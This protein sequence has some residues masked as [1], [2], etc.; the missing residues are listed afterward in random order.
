MNCVSENKLFT[1]LFNRRALLGIAL[2][3]STLLPLNHAAP[4]AKSLSYSNGIQTETTSTPPPTSS[5]PVLTTTTTAKVTSTLNGTFQTDKMNDKVVSPPVDSGVDATAAAASIVATTIEKTPSMDDKAIEYNHN[6][7]T[8]KSN[9]VR[10]TTSASSSNNYLDKNNHSVLPI[11]V[12]ISESQT[13]PSSTADKNIDVLSTSSPSATTEPTAGHSD[14]FVT[15]TTFITHQHSSSTE[16]ILSDVRLQS[17]K[18]PTQETIFTTENSAQTAATAKPSSSILGDLMSATSKPSSDNDATT[19]ISKISSLTEIDELSL[20]VN[21]EEHL[22]GPASVQSETSNPLSTKASVQT[23]D[24]DKDRDD[25]AVTNENRKPFDV[26]A[27]LGHAR[28]EATQTTVLI[29]S[30]STVASSGGSIGNGDGSDGAIAT[31]K[32]NNSNGGK[33]TK[34]LDEEKLSSKKAKQE[35]IS[36]NNKKYNSKNNKDKSKKKANGEDEDVDDRGGEDNNGKEEGG[37]N[38][39]NGK[40]NDNLS[41]ESVSF[42]QK[43]ASS[44]FATDVRPAAVQT[45]TIRSMETHSVDGDSLD[46]TASRK[47]PILDEIRT[48]ESM[49]NANV[50]DFTPT[51]IVSVVDSHISSTLNAQDPISTVTPSTTTTRETPTKTGVESTVQKHDTVGQKITSTTFAPELETKEPINEASFSDKKQL[52]TEKATAATEV[53]ENNDS[54]KHSNGDGNEMNKAD[55]E[56]V[57]TNGM[58]AKPKPTT[59]P[60]SILDYDKSSEEIFDIVRETSTPK[61]DITSTVPEKR[62]HDANNDEF[63]LPADDLETDATVTGST[64]TSTTAAVVTTSAPTTIQ[65]TVPINTESAIVRPNTDSLGPTITAPIPIVTSDTKQQTTDVNK[66]STISRD[67]DTIFYISNTEVKVVESVPT[68]NS[69]QENQFFP[70]LFEEDV[71]IDFPG[72]IFIYKKNFIKRI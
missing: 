9:S 67:S 8:I 61:T 29:K 59:G 56:F 34:V 40:L 17:N 44:S 25:V 38:D 35:S 72:K 23:N 2:L 11:S 1:V 51:S 53:T 37:V 39:P 28:G 46:D 30:A 63:F 54:N 69:K 66:A 24:N 21:A 4:T 27:E 3:L 65:S 47:S 45:T 43:P 52:S 62:P 31:A 18:N 68:P 7:A 70:A 26:A 12:L 32:T 60:P 57:H 22:N 10:V 55:N 36:N 19:T 41:M 14:D 48:T 13:Q 71:I 42:A 16:T 6:V 5:S 64:T 33:V 58:K 49:I 50:T 15:T 20:N